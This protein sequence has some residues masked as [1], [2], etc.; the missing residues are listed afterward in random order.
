MIDASVLWHYSLFD[1]LEQ[2]QIDTILPMMVEEE[3][4]AG[5]AIITEGEQNDKIYFITEGRV[6]VSKKKITLH[7]LEEGSIF[8]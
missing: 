3:Y 5:N 8:G 4:S 7:I 6:L 1:G 2:E